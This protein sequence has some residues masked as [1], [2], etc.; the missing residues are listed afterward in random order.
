MPNSEC[1]KAIFISNLG[2]FKKFK[3]KNIFGLTGTLGSSPEK[4]FIKTIYNLD[5]FVMPRFIKQ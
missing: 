4:N 1:L 2:F 3:S 5:S